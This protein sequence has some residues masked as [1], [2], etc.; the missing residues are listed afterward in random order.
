MANRSEIKS[1]VIHFEKCIDFL[2]KA[3]KKYIS[4]NFKILEHDH[5]IIFK[6][7]VYFYKDKT[8]ASK[9]NLNLN[10][11][12]LLTGPIGCGKTS[13]MT[14]FRFMLAPE[15]QYILKT[16]RD[17]SLEFIEQGFPV[18]NK[19]SKASFRQVGGKLVPK[20]YCFDDLGVE[21]NIKYYGNDTNVMA[22]ILLSRYDIFIS[23]KMLTH[24]TSNLSA[25][26]IEEQYGN[27]VRSRLRQA[28]NV[29]AFDSNTEDKR[30]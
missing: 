6:L 21:S 13:L 17:I 22:E 26:E 16:T 30:K 25:S 2:E 27:R 10:K 23:Q 7:L 19:Y 8:N 24:S 20:T 9:Y 5:E 12:I 29:I 18:I 11:G 15:N 4:S 1:K 28:M 3:G 14:L